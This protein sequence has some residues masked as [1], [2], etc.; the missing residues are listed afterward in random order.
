MLTAESFSTPVCLCVSDAGYDA[1]G[2][3]RKYEGWTGGYVFA[4]PK[5][6]AYRARRPS[7]GLAKVA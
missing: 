7:V 5:A 6:D 4:A 2:D 3:P 1:A